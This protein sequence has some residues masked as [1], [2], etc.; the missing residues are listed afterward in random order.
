MHLPH[1]YQLRGGEATVAGVRVRLRWNPPLRGADEWLANSCGR[2]TRMAGVDDQNPRKRP[3]RSQR[4]R[5]PWMRRA[6]A[7]H[8]Y[9][10]YYERWQE[11]RHDLSDLYAGVCKPAEPI[12]EVVRD[13]RYI[14]ELG[15]LQNDKAAWARSY[16][17]SIEALAQAYG[18]DRLGRD[19]QKG[20]GQ[21]R[22]SEGEQFIHTWCQYNAVNCL[23]FEM[24]PD[25][26][27]FAIL[28]W[29]GGVLPELGESSQS[30]PV[31]IGLDAEWDPVGEKR[32]DAED[33]LVRLAREQIQA[34][35]LAITR[36]AERL[37]YTFPDTTPKAGQHI[38]YVFQHEALGMS[39]GDIAKHWLEGADQA[40]TIQKRAKPYIDLI[41]V[42]P[43][44][45]PPRFR[46]SPKTP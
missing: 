17:A 11:F 2:A 23:A 15:Q 16:L 29:P 41:G 31:R 13:F 9:L 39:W 4:G 7:R 24:K 10:K 5:L 19:P 32:S 46:R 22:P 44:S 1:W 42:S 36:R 8:V 34:Q 33:R 25:P 37:G 21:F 38:A 35:L 14:H 6:E 3:R 40:D 27:L 45:T 12:L 26:D 28:A 43:R 30:A 20:D 18:L